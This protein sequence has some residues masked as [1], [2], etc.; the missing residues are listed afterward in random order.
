MPPLAALTAPVLA[1]AETDLLAARW[2][3]ALSLGFHIVLACL[4]VALPTIIWIV[5]RRG[6][7]NADH[8]ALLLARR[9]GKVAAVLFAVGAVSGTVLSFLMGLLWPGLMGDFGDVIGLAFAFEGIFFFLEAI[10][11]GIYLYGWKGLPARI[12]LAT[13]IPIGLSGVFGTL[14]ILAVNGWMNTPAGFDIETYL[15]TGEVTDV[16]PWAAF[17]NES[18]W[19]QFAHMLP[20]TYVVAGFGTASIFA[21]GWL[22]GR[23]DRLHRLGIV[24]PLVVGC[25]AIPVQVITGDIVARHVADT[26]PAKF[27]AMEIHEETGPAGLALFGFESGGEIRAK[28]EIPGLTSLILD[29]DPD[30]TVTGLDAIPEDET[31]PVNVVR[32]SF[33]LMIG[34][35]VAMLAAAAW[36]GWCWWRTRAIPLGDGFVRWVVVALGP[37]SVLALWAGWTTT[38]VGRQPWIAHGVLR[39][40]DAVTDNTVAPFLVG[41]IAVYTGLGA[42]AWFVLRRLAVRWNAGEE[43]STPYGPRTP[44][45][46]DDARDPVTAGRERQP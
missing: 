33:Q 37:A 13:L 19:P 20:A 32:F 39:V 2:M 26:Q 9:L 3:M 14:C 35:G 45:D 5:H 28:V 12:H 18:L 11:L 30:A 38:E 44:S 16:D 6:L 43:V 4:G 42:S 21:I 15:A 25:I 27:A 24:I 36:V 1:A 22:R 10:F 46:R 31:P 41:L 29:F 17:F 7:R 40:S 8:D 23:R 34:L